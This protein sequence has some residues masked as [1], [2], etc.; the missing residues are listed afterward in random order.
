M[1]AAYLI[2]AVRRNISSITLLILERA[3]GL[4]AA[5]SYDL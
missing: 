3:G 1:W 2:T 4:R 5:Y